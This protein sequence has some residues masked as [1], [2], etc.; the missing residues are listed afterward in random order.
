MPFPLHSMTLRLQASAS[1]VF[2]VIPQNSVYSLLTSPEQL[3]Q[4]IQSHK[5]SAPS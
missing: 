1:L 3:L 5:L 4:G 2:S